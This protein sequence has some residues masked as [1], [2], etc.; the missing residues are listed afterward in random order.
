[1]F[2]T[3]FRCDGA[4]WLPNSRWPA[5]P[6]NSPS[7]APGAAARHQVKSEVVLAAALCSAG[8]VERA[9]AVADTALH[10]TARLRLVP[11]RWALGAC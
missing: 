4:G 7:G 9:R 2:P 3:V 10:T 8:D 6:A 11:L 1:M 5:A